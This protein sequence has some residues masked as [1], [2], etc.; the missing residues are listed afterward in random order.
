MNPPGRFITVEGVEGAGKTT[1]MAVLAEHLRDR[2][3][4]APVTTREPGGTRL[5]E[6][7]REVLLGAG[8]VGIGADAELLLLFSARAQHLEEVIH[9]AL[10]RGEWVLC[11]R[12]TDA[13]YAYQGGGRGISAERI[14]TL[15]AWTQGRLR[16][17]LTLVLD[18]P[19]PEGRRRAS[20][21]SA[22]DRFEQERDPFFE[23]VR[24]TYL[25]RAAAE[26]ERVRVVD[27]DADQATVAARIRATVDHWLGESGA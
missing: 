18:L 15:E 14:A 4:T 16:P 13:S 25:E 27:G 8:G 7:I 20:D 23:R 26:P 3:G 12:F 11:D 1:A 19:V 17:D 6:A 5:G 21:R 2:T 24:N 9:P 10:A 22:P